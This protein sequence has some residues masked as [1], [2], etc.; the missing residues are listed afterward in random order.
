M[1]ET[2]PS[3]GYGGRHFQHWQAVPKPLRDPQVPEVVP[4]RYRCGRRG[5]TVR[6]YPH[7]VSPDQTR[8]RLQGV[9]VMV[10]VLRIELLPNGETATVRAWIAEL[11][12]VL[13]AALLRSDEAAP[14]EPAADESGLDHQ[15]GTAHVRRNTAA[16]GEAITP[17]LAP[18]AA[19]SLAAIGVAPAPAVAD[20]QE[21]RCLMTERQPSPAASA[22][23]AA[24]HP[25]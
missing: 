17:S 5:R 9:A 1:V 20:C 4:P 16:W 25:R 7:G 13:G 18:D 22:A 19:G 15:V 3:A 2:C 6:G 24:I 14:F 23:L 12:T 21:L 10:S 8:A 11:A